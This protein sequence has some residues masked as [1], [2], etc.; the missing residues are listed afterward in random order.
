[1]KKKTPYQPNALLWWVAIISL[2]VSISVF[3]LLEEQAKYDVQ[4]RTQRMLFPLVG[5]LIAGVCLITGTAKL[6]FHSK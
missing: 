5:I 1:M 3:F 6:W 2:V 4:I